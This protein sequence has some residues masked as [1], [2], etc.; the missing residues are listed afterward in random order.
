MLEIY[1]IGF[2]PLGHLPLGNRDEV[3]PLQNILKPVSVPILNHP[4]QS[5]PGYL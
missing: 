1:L 5:F 2:F 3:L 4:P